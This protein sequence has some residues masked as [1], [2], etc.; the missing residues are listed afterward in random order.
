MGA[1]FTKVHMFF[2]VRGVENFGNS[3][4]ATFSKVGPRGGRGSG[5]VGGGE[6][7]EGSKGGEGRG[8]VELFLRECA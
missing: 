1:R 4:T 6:E 2:V 8:G 5:G 7:G 3:F